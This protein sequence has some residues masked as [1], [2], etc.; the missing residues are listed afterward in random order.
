MPVELR[1]RHTR[2]SYKA[3]LELPDDEGDP[4]LPEDDASSQSAFEAAYTEDDKDKAE[5]E[6][7]P[8]ETENRE[9]STQEDEFDTA[10]GPSKPKGKGKGEGKEKGRTA[11]TGRPTMPS[12]HRPAP[13]ML[14]PGLSRP[15]ARQNYALPLPNLNHRHRGTPVYLPPPRTLRLVDKPWI[16]FHPET[17]LTRSIADPVVRERV[18]RATGHNLGRGPVWELIEDL[19]W[20]KECPSGDQTRP[21]VY[22]TLAVD[23]GWTLLPPEYVVAGLYGPFLI[24]PSAK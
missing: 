23:D 20:F 21:I 6:G 1:T 14:A 9:H 15:N 3:L 4:P 22:D 16:F 2:P 11:S 18:N 24:Y 7:A 19:S 13:G 8:H 10:P 12:L 5:N 17:V